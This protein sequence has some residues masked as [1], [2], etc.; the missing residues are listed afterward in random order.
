MQKKIVKKF[1]LNRHVA[2]P[3]PTLNN[4]KFAAH[5]RQVTH[6]V[7]TPWTLSYLG[8][9]SPPWHFVSDLGNRGPGVAYLHLELRKK[10]DFPREESHSRHS[11]PNPGNGGP[12]VAYLGGTDGHRALG[13][14]LRTFTLCTNA[15]PFHMQECPRTL[16]RNHPPPLARLFVVCMHL[17]RRRRL[18]GR[19]VNPMT[20]TQS[21]SLPIPL[22]LEQPH[23]CWSALPTPL[24]AWGNPRQPG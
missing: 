19:K 12:G 21:W 14:T 22:A 6:S 4:F 24:A 1:N 3:T 5:V 7:M 13:P 17:P 8:G 2:L 20:Q 10:P 16:A 18:P 23:E 9:I 15:S 11:V